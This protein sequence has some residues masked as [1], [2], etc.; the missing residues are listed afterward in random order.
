MSA[1]ANSASTRRERAASHPRTPPHTFWPPCTGHS[2]PTILLINVT[3][4]PRRVRASVK[5]PLR[6]ALLTK[7]KTSAPPQ[8]LIRSFSSAPCAASPRLVQRDGA[9]EMNPHG[10]LPH[11]TD[12]HLP[13]WHRNM[14]CRRA[15]QLLRELPVRRPA[16]PATS[17]F[18]RFEHRLSLFPPDPPCYTFDARCTK[19]CRTRVCAQ[20]RP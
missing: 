18:A 12:G 7:R 2:A 15:A 4:S 6:C 13:S 17:C 11:S 3:D 20:D 5:L 9:S 8:S 1:I 19:R 16:S 14:N 10:P